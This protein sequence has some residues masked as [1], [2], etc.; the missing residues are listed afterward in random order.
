[1][2]KSVWIASLTLVFYLPVLGVAQDAPAE[3]PKTGVEVKSPGIPDKETLFKKFTDSMSNVK[4]V[5]RFTV[6]GKDNGP[7]NKEEYTILSATKVEEGDKWLLKARIKYGDHDL[8]VPLLID[9]V[10][11][12]DTPVI[13]LTN[14]NIPGLGTFGS[15]VLIYDNSY[16]GTWTHGKAGGHLF[17][18]IEKINPAASPVTSDKPAK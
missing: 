17:G 1:M 15:R 6:L 11:A 10:W 9:I 3:K 4:L 16:A 5:G 7:L 13:T 18:T 8:T 12:G 2:C 14:F